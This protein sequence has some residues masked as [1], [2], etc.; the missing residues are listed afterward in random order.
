MFDY[1]FDCSKGLY[2]DKHTREAVDQRY[3]TKRWDVNLN[4]LE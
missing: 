1:K 3:G 4:R 2:I